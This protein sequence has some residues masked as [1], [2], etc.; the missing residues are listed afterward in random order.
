[1][2]KGASLFPQAI[3][4]YVEMDTKP[5]YP[6]GYGLS[7]SNFE[8]SNFTCDSEA[9]CKKGIANLSFEVK[10]TGTVDSDEVSMIFIK[11]K[12]KGVT[13]PVK[14]LIGFTRYNLKNGQSKT[15]SMSI[16]TELFGFFDE[17]L[18]FKVADGELTLCVGRSSED[19]VFE[20]TVVLTGNDYYIENRSEFYI[21]DIEIK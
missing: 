13:L 14:K 9:L 6:F 21:E 8:Y 12:N 19:F 20:N 11:Q 2:V 7:Y 18:R 15:V 5:L 3:G 1:M 4:I 17:A 10:N 16:P